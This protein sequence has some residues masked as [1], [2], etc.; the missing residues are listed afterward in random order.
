VG[1]IPSRAFGL[2][3]LQ[4][5]AGKCRDGMVAHSKGFGHRGFLGAYGIRLYIVDVGVDVGD[6]NGRPEALK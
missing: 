2:T 5:E 3:I 1:L 4:F 6:H